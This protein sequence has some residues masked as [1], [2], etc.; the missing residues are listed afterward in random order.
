MKVKQSGAPHV[1]ENRY[2]GLI[3]GCA[4]G[5]LGKEEGRSKELIWPPVTSVLENEK[6]RCRCR[7]YVSN[8]TSDFGARSLFNEFSRA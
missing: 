6:Y 7:V 8:P 2:S 5:F 4:S 3:I 1:G